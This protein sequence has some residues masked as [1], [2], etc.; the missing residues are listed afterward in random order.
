MG[1]KKKKRFQT[2]AMH[3]KKKSFYTRQV[4]YSDKRG[5]ANRPASK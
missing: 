1:V 2:L 5:K 3:P 4:L